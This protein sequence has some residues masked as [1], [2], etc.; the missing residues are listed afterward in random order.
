MKKYV[1][2]LCVIG[3]LLNGCSKSDVNSS[4]ELQ[5]SESEQSQERVEI[6]TDDAER[7][8]RIAAAQSRMSELVRKEAELQDM[9][10]SGQ[11]IS[12]NSENDAQS[13]ETDAEPLPDAG[14]IDESSAEAENEDEPNNK[15]ERESTHPQEVETGNERFLLSEHVICID[16][17][18]SVTP[19]IG[20]GYTG[21]VSPLSNE[22]KP[23]YTAGAEGPHITEERLNLLI[24]LKLR[25][26]L[27]ALGAEVLMTREVSEVAITGVERCEIANKGG[28]DVNIHIH[29]DGVDDSRAHG[30]SVLVPGGDL[31]GTPSIVEESV[32]LGKIMVDC[33][34]EATGAK[35]RGITTRSDLTG[36]NFS[37]VPS[38]FIEMGFLSNLEEEAK[39]A[40]EEYQDKIVEGMITSLLEWYGIQ[41]SGR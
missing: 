11:E 24:G 35:N 10:T 40:T 41:I 13:P 15:P 19:L 5:F 33:V 29:A 16:P 23:L 20:K 17:G 7:N 22:E 8:Q 30:V 27:Q 36:L 18:H 3:I 12:G 32:R 39:L 6:P 26:A 31:L 14:I 9:E 4:G 34:S 38:V 2:L 21:P 25:D 37:E 28:A 1:V